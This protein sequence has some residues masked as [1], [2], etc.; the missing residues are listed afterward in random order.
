MSSLMLSTAIRNEAPYRTVL[1]HGFTVDAQGRKM[2]KSIGN[3]VSP[4]DVIAKMGADVLRLWVASTDYTGDMTVSDEIFR[5]SAD[6]YRRIRNTTRFLLANLNGF[7]PE[8]NLVA[9][10]EM[11]ALD[12]WAVACACEFQKEIIKAYEAFDFHTV[13]QKIMEFCS[14]EM[15][16]FYLDII[17]DRQYTAKADSLARRSCQS[18]LYHIAEALVRW[19]APVLS[20]TAQETWSFMPGKRDKYVFTAEWYDGLAPLS[21]DA[22]FNDSFWHE[23]KQVRDE[24]YKKLEDARNDRIIGSPLEADVVIYA[25]EAK[26]SILDRLEN[27]LIYVL[28]VSHCDVRPLAEKPESAKDADVAGLAFEVRHSS[29]KKCTRCWHYEDSVG[30][31]AGHEDVCTRCVTNIDGTGEIRKFA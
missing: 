8:K 27:E 17:K 23:V 22:V 18:A 13:V 4:Q 11:V 24:V 9:L 26:K 28:I 30:T 19:F 25:D 7:D 20:F 21:A 14:V 31:I 3:V 12:R 16:S 1:T 29:A 5:R 6:A 10:D 2:S 15:G